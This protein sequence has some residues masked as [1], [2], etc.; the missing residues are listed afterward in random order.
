MKLSNRNI[1]LIDDTMM[2]NGSN[3][4]TMSKEVTFD[5]KY[6]LILE[7]TNADGTKLSSVSQIKKRK[8]I[9]VQYLGFEIKVFSSKKRISLL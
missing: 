2:T 5:F 6:P 4:Y 8:F 7:I 1:V 3:R 9:Y